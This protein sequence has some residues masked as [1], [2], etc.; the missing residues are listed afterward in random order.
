MKEPKIATDIQFGLCDDPECKSIHFQ[1]YDGEE[2]FAQAAVPVK[3]M[4]SLIDRLQQLAY[5]IVTKEKS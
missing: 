4:P 3:Y 2:L 1:L 5:H